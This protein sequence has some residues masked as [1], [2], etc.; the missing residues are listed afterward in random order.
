MKRWSYGIN[1][2]Y[3]TSNLVLEEAPWYIFFIEWFGLFS[4]SYIPEIPFPDILPKKRNK[5]DDCVCKREKRHC[6]DHDELYTLKEWYG[7]LRQWYHGA[8]CSPITEWTNG[9]IKQYMFKVSYEEVF[10]NFY[11]SDKEF[12]DADINTAKELEAEKF[13]GIDIHEN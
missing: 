11:K 13:F 7:D 3:K 2:Y 10:E 8:V 5:V 4:C 1:S 9:K 12:F 6:E